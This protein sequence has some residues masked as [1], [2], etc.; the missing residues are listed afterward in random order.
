LFVFPFPFNTSPL[1]NPMVKDWF[2]FPAFELQVPSFFFQSVFF[3]VSLPP[4]RKDSILFHLGPSPLFP[5]RGS[6]PPPVPHP[7]FFPFSWSPLSTKKEFS[8][9]ISCF[10]VSLLWCA[11]SDA[12]TV[13][14]LL[15]PNPR[16]FVFFSS[17]WF[18]PPCSPFE[19]PWT[20]S[21]RLGEA[22]QISCFLFFS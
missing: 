14:A 22:G 13:C 10:P 18:D 9:F 5:F 17:S 2:F 6:A 19:D 3:L 16:F 7:F 21:S 8:F 4:H 20:S 11:I 12:W 15:P 1:T